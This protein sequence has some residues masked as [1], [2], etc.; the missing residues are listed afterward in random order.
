M[1]RLAWEAGITYDKIA[2]YTNKPS[3]LRLDMLKEIY[4]LTGKRLYLFVDRVSIVRDELHTLLK[5]NKT[6]GIPLTVVCAER[7]NEWLVYCDFLVPF[8]TQDF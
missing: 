3:G 7:E 8:L 2:L 4:A 5:D 6:G 1:K